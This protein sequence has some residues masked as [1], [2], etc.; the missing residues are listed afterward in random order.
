VKKEENQYFSK[1]IDK[2]IRILSL[3]NPDCIGLSL[4]EISQKTGINITSTYRFVDTYIQLG[5]LKK[6]SRAKLIKLGPKA[7]TLAHN[8]IRSFDLR[9]IVTPFLDEV[10]DTYNISIESALLEGDTLLTIY[11]RSAKDTL[12]FHLPSIVK[13]IHCTA[14]GKA[15]LA[16]LPEDEVLTI[17]NR[18]NL[19]ARTKNS[20]TDKNSLLADLKK[21]RER[22]YSLA[23]EEFILGYISISS[24]FSNIHNN[25]P[26]GAVAFDFPTVG[27]SLESIESEYAR[28]SIDISKEISNVVSV[29]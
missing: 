29:A 7:L 3:F 21:T 26:V 24:P 18:I 19:V 12:S 6:D 15:I 16:H 8:F 17:I 25:R 28:I 4:K 10:Y 2:G 14:L 20:L 9:Q 5:Y 1:I 27:H 13:E 11:Q 22:G 23:N